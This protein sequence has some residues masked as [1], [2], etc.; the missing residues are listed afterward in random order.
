[1]NAM[2]DQPGQP[3]RQT[4]HQPPPYRQPPPQQPPPQQPPQ[5]QW[6]V[7]PAYPQ[8]PAFQ[9]PPPARRDTARRG[10]L[11]LL[12]AAVVLGG[13]AGFGGAALHD[14][15]AGGGTP[16]GTVDADQ[17]DTGSVDLQDLVSVQTVAKQA[18]PTV[19]KIESIGA[20]SGSTGS[21][22]ILSE[23]GEIL[24]NFHVAFEGIDGTLEV[25]F[26]DGS[27]A[28]AEI[29]G[30]DESMDIALIKAQDVSGLKTARLGRSDTVDVGQA[31]VAVGS[32]YGLDATVT[33]GI[34][35]TL[36]RPVAVG[37]MEDP[38]VPMVYPALQT[39]AA[40]NPGNSGGALV[41]IKGE[42][43]GVN[44]ANKLAS[45]GDPYSPGDLG[46]I[47]IGWAI[48]IHVI[49]PILEQLR[50]GDEP[51]H[52]W[53]GIVP[54]NAT[55]AGVPQ[56]AL[57]KEFEP[58]SSAEEAGV[59]TGDVVVGIDDWKVQD[60]LGLVTTALQYRPGDEV[61]L[62]LLRDGEAQE[63]SVTLGEKGNLF[64]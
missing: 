54:G 51:T 52:A 35:S 47:G 10:G 46:S 18:L 49:E 13:A 3:Y 32:P 61:T 43:I 42:L 63:L 21:G 57:V 45:S 6:G 28:E 30:F 7:Q 24:T 44:S 16:N 2:T 53:L 26:N 9:P 27:T 59:R 48:P 17:I 14:E 40:I 33:A 58:D 8:R 62:S 11:G 34:I 4:P 36:N 60:K 31:V 50:A 64:E 22:I 19:V 25:F 39:D 37:G 5:Q 15:T 23:D 56:G 1:M 41:N 12:V 38:D 55:E 29:V 20:T